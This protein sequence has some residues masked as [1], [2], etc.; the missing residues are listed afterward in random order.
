MSEK[1]RKRGSVEDGPPSKKIAPAAP[2][3]NEVKVTFVPDNEELCPVVA[4]TPGLSIPTNIPLQPYKKSRILTPGHKPSKSGT[5]E[6]LLQS[7]NHPRLDYTA[8]EEHDGSADSLLKHYVGVFDPTTSELTVTEAHKIVVRSTLRSEAEEMREERERRAA[9]VAQKPR[10]SALKQDLGMTFGTKKA[11]KAI[12]SITENA[13]S[14]GAG[15]GPGGKAPVGSVAAAVVDA[16]AAAT[17][18]MPTRDE[19]Q[20]DIDT[21][22]PRPTPNTN[23]T[24]PAEVYTLES[25]VGAD[26]VR[27]IKVKDWLDAVKENQD[28][29]TSSRFVSRR[30]ETVAKI[31][32]I[33]KLKALKYILLLIDFHNVL[34]SAGKDGGKKLPQADDM[35]KKLGGYGALVNGAK[36]N[37][38][39]KGMVTS[40]YLDKLRTHV[41]ALALIVDNFQTDVS[42]LTGDL[43][44]D[45]AGMSKYFKEIGCKVVALSEDERVKLGYSKAEAAAHK[46]AKLR[47]PLEFPKQR[48]P[49]QKK[50]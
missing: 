46:Q 35:A 7:S 30:L 42:G 4:S 49:R 2:S 50:R 13:I 37:F 39:D 24:T 18:A 34:K 31:P 28:V 9:E 43:R 10:A 19:M 29:K 47:L 17:A 26:T 32:D 21:T 44:L 38:S 14:Q 22:K 40:W 8:R 11:K 1:K 5:Y 16:M 41:A 6:L 45:S 15:G 3:T 48:T 33:K 36:R 12:A 25:L 27:E 23:A 20:A